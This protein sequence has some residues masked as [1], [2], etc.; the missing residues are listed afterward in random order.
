MGKTGIEQV[1]TELKL[2]PRA[3]VPLLRSVK[4]AILPSHTH[5]RTRYEIA[6]V[7]LLSDEAQNCA[8]RI[9]LDLL[10]RYRFE[11]G[12]SA[13]PH[14]SLKLGFK[15]FD[16][17]P[18]EEYFDHLVGEIEPVEVVL[19]NFGFFDE[20]IVFLDVDPNPVLEALRQRIIA[21]LK[22]KFSILPQPIEGDA[23]HFHATLA[24][25]LSKPD[26]DQVRESLRNELVCF[27][28]MATSC[29][30]FF[31]MDGQWITYKQATLHAK[32]GC[33]ES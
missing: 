7:L 16:V 22:D 4:R 23:Y 3:F 14:I 9:Q 24:H 21:D 2:L 33:P 13:R 1:T 17:E 29:A 28:F 25:G 30:L 19:R 11:H 15:T 5:P 12:I 6:I 18:I 20:G 32:L 31:N 10:K 27:R 26:F 8:R